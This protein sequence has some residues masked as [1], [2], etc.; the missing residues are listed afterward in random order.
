L[1]TK[2]WQKN[3]YCQSGLLPAI[4][5][6]A[7][8]WAP[9]L[10]NGLA[11]APACGIYVSMNG[12]EQK[13]LSALLELEAAVEGMSTKSPKPDLMPIFERL[14]RLSVEL[15]SGTD[16]ALTH[17]LQKKSYQK[18]RLWLQGRDAENQRGAC[19]PHQ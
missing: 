17:Y 8:P 7:S 6:R 12:S 1:A 3:N 19:G 15:P 5:D 13:L 16:P 18:A 10:F 4:P 9:E 11:L 2:C 14:D